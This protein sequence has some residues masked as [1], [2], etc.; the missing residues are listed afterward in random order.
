MEAA[1]PRPK[2]ADSDTRGACAD[3]RGSAIAPGNGCI[4][5][6]PSKSPGG[7]KRVPA[8]ISRH[9]PTEALKNA[10]GT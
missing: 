9:Q 4:K 5:T 2:D 8:T 7:G 10:H 6:M 1:D 3:C